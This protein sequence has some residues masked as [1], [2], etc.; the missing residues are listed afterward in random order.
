MLGFWLSLGYAVV[1]KT[2]GAYS[3]LGDLFLKAN[4]ILIINSKL[5]RICKAMKNMKC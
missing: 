1:R 4:A 5:C 2:H 3:S